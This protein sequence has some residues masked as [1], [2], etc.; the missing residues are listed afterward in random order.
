MQKPPRIWISNAAPKAGDTVRV[1]AQIEHRM[2]SGLRLDAK[3]QPIARNIVTR[4][5]ARLGND[6]LFTWSP[7]T[8][9]AQNP[10]LEFTFKAR[11]PGELKMLWRDDLG[12]TLT[13]S[14]TL[15]ISST[16]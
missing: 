12:Q 11:E 3:G 8:A 2:E 6:L 4:F 5:E 7:E 13:A 10:F 1:R 15:E 9:I 16:P 14:K